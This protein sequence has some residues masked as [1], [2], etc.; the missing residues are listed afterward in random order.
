MEF[1]V[2]I[3]SSD[4]VVDDIVRDSIDRTWIPLSGITYTVQVDRAPACDSAVL[5]FSFTNLCAATHAQGEAGGG[6]RASEHSPRV[7]NHV[8]SSRIGR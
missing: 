1:H 4:R 5:R 8:E 3:S 6:T 2:S 7:A